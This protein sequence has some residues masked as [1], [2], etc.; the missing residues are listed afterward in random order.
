[1]SIVD[2]LKL[3]EEAQKKESINVGDLIV[4]V[5]DAV[6]LG[7]TIYRSWH[8]LDNSIS[9]EWKIVAILGLWGLDIGATAWSI[10]WMFAASN[11]YQDWTSIGMFL[12]DLVGMILTSLIDSLV[13]A[14][15]GAVAVP[16]I[17]QQGAQYAIPIIIIMN[18]V[19]GFLYHMISDRTML[20]REERKAK[21][22]LRRAYQK[23]DIESKRKSLDIQQLKT[24]IDA[25]EAQLEQEQDLVAQMLHLDAI[26][27]GLRQARESRDLV[28]AAAKNTERRVTGAFQ[29]R[30]TQ[31]EKPAQREKAG[32][33]L[34][35]ITAGKN[36]N[37]H[38]SNGHSKR[39]LDNDSSLPNA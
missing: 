4:L 12:V 33:I 38:G 9:A 6:L 26:E 23:H 28:D 22:D 5:L 1:M 24:F 27:K 10:V 37:N 18:V 3:Q 30:A 39:P 20:M 35:R 13:Y 8:F 25:R 21:S 19:A 29:Q 11:R 7:F 31:P 17:I 34:E 32:A 16:D 15:S 2:E 14:K 36:G